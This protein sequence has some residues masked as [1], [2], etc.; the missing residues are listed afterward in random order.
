MGDT[1][2]KRKETREEAAFR[3][4]SFFLLRFLT[5]KNKRSDD[6]TVMIYVILL[7]VA[8]CALNS[9]RVRSH[10]YY[11]DKKNIF[12]GV[13]RCHRPMLIRRINWRFDISPLSLR[14]RRRRLSTKIGS[15][16]ANEQDLALVPKLS[17]EKPLMIS[18][19][20]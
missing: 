8:S 15:S 20:N 17:I 13:V 3:I 2:K 10:S 6:A 19:N 14:R 7:S 12:R 5:R 18:S 4:Q 11:S 1:H 9:D 16:E